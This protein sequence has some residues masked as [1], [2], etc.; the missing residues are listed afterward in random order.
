MQEP[1]DS[2]PQY[3]LMLVISLLSSILGLFAWLATVRDP[4]GLAV[5]MPVILMTKVLGLIVLGAMAGS[6]AG[7]SVKAFLI[8]QSDAR[9]G[10]RL[11]FGM[12]G[13]VSMTATAMIAV[14][15]F[16]RV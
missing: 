3:K 8:G 9:S 6:F 7:L 14:I 10:W 11:V 12:T 13:V 2:A 5:Q 15:G 4:V 16:G 1:P